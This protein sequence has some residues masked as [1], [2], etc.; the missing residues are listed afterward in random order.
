ML[1]DAELEQ[2][3]ALQEEAMDDACEVRGPGTGSVFDPDTGQTTTNP[4]PLRY[5]GCCRAQADAGSIAAREVLVAG[6]EV[7]TH[8]Y[9]VALPWHVTTV[10]K[11]DVVTITMSRDPRLVDRELIVGDIQGSS[12]AT[13]RRLLCTDDLG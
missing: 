8:V 12:F 5:A 2:A 6:D 13:A 7:A 10:A 4:G 1:S 11:H 9:P 3:R